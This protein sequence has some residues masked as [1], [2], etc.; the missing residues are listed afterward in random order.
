[1]EYA[2]QWSVRIMHEVQLHDVN[3][4]LTLTH[5]DESLPAFGSLD[6]LAFPGFMKRLRESLNPCW[7]DG[8]QGPKV[9]IRYFMAGEYGSQ[10][11]RPHYHACLFGFDFPDK[12]LHSVRHGYPVWTSE[13]LQKLWPLGLCEIGSVTSASASYVARY[14]VKKQGLKS[15]RY[16]KVDLSTGEVHRV[17]PEFTLMSRRPGIGRAWLDRYMCEVY[18]ADS[19]VV[20]GRLEK[21]PRR[22][23]DWY[24]IGA[25]VDFERVQRLRAEKRVLREE[26]PERLVARERCASARLA[27][28]GERG[29]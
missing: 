27:L 5:D 24:S 12:A 9:C 23:D 25:P 8:E 18:P 11:F 19:V 22:Y 20:R 3:C 26:R 13:Y 6:K 17:S 7:A 10:S 4:F 16:D 1:M 28:K 21:P 14:C 29:L 2:R 15:G